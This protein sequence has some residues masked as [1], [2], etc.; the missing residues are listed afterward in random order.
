[1]KLKE[2]KFLNSKKIQ[3]EITIHKKLI[4]QVFADK[5][6][7]IKKLI[8]YQ[9]QLTDLYFRQRLA[10]NQLSEIYH[11]NKVA[12]MALLN[13]IN[14]SY[15]IIQLI[16]NGF[17]GSARVLLRQFFEFLIIGKFSEF[18]S[19]NLIH[20]WESKTSN[21][22][23]FDINLSRDVLHIIRSKKDVGHLQKMWK[24]LSDFSHPTKYAQQLPPFSTSD[25]HLT[26][27]KLSYKNI[28]YT[29]DLF[30][31]LL[32]M[33]HHLLISNWG[34]KT[35]GWYMGYYKDPMGFWKREKNIKGK[36]KTTIKKYF[37]LNDELDGPNTELKKTIFQY[38]QKWNHI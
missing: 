27:M 28:H 31:M 33:N 16:E 32:C 3:G 25:D 10:K 26:W 11:D 13:Q 36:T 22:K 15:S 8:D 5:I 12:D 29:L 19:G 24:I 9:I 6:T 1:M 21:N 17:F 38:K 18:D 23:E 14:L 34:K 7:L 20:K 37:Q 30:F 2:S 35:S 4:K